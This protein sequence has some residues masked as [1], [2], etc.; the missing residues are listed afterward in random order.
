MKK[1]KTIL[2]LNKK[3]I[4]ELSDVH[5]IL[6]GDNTNTAN[7]VITSTCPTISEGFVFVETKC[8]CDPLP[9]FDL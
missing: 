3:V 7:P 1:K 4:A 6:G 5:K 2:S 9:N 8:L